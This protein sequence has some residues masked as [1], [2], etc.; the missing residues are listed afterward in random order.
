MTAQR[1]V[2]TPTLVLMAL[3][4]KNNCRHESH[5]GDELCHIWGWRTEAWEIG[6]QPALQ[7]RVGQNV[8]LEFIKRGSQRSFYLGKRGALNAAPSTRR[9]HLWIIGGNPSINYRAI[10]DSSIIFWSRWNM[11]DLAAVILIIRLSWSAFGKD[12][13]S[14][15]TKDLVLTRDMSIKLLII[16]RRSIFLYCK[17]LIQFIKLPIYD[18]RASLT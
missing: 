10:K 13:R 4:L 11:C 2:L 17:P 8:P 3:S 6:A 15:V 14:N 5:K 1:A 16:V 18:F 12:L 7:A 9:R